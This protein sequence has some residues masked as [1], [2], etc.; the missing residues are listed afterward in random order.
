MD[1]L[2]VAAAA[3]AVSSAAFAADIPLTLETSVDGTVHCDALDAKFLSR[4]RR[5]DG[6]FAEFMAKAEARPDGTLRWTFDPRAAGAQNFVMLKL[7]AARWAGGRCVSG[8]ETA[9]MPRE[10]E[11][12]P[13]LLHQHRRIACSFA[14]ILQ[15][16]SRE[17]TLRANTAA[18]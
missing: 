3:F 9:E 1:V 7:D 11:K 4:Q 2:V 6:S 12:A 18:V 14:E 10:H 16:L 13:D 17:Y 15:A 5:A 8:T